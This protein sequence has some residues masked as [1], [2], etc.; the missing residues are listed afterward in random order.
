M[1]SLKVHLESKN[2]LDIFS[3]AQEENEYDEGITMSSITFSNNSDVLAAF[4]EGRIGLI[5]VLNEC[6]LR[7]NDG[8]DAPLGSKMKK[9]NQDT[10]SLVVQHPL[11]TPTQ[12]AIAHYA[13]EVV[14]DATN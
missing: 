2:N 10:P 14:Y 8:N 1:G 12:F 7:A 4:V 9:V 13:A 3:S 6:L 5:S 11:H